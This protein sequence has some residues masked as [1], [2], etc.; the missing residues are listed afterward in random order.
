MT[1]VWMP[2]AD[3]VL[4][5]PHLWFSRPEIVEYVMALAHGSYELGKLKKKTYSDFPKTVNH[6]SSKTGK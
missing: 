2:L 3:V 1:D 5:W 4:R 6:I